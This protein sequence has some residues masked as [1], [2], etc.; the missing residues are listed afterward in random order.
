MQLILVDSISLFYR[1]ENEGTEVLSDLPEAQP[2]TGA[3]VQKPC[4]PHPHC[5][6]LPPTD[7]HPLSS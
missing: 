7:L 6:A 5:T 2:L 1:R 3:G 4:P